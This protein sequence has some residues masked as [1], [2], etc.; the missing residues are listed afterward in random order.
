MKLSHLVLSETRNVKTSVECCQGYNHLA[1]LCIACYGNV[2]NSSSRLY[3]E[4]LIVF[5]ISDFILI[6]LLFDDD[7]WKKLLKSLETDFNPYFSQQWSGWPSASRIQR[8]CYRP[9]GGSQQIH[10]SRQLQSRSFRPFLRRHHIRHNIQS[11]TLNFHLLISCVTSSSIYRFKLPII[12]TCNPLQTMISDSN[13]SAKCYKTL[14]NIQTAS[15]AIFKFMIFA[16]YRM[17]I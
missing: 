5:N 6:T 8:V 2:R 17:Y 11:T 12:Q 9:S 1:T 3:G 15:Q 14:R 13:S 10:P 4:L 16:L 7:L